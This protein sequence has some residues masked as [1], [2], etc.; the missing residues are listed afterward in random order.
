[1]A[2]ISR[3]KLIELYRDLPSDVAA[4][5]ENASTS[6]VMLD[7]GRKNSIPIDQLGRLSYEVGL[8]MVGASPAREFIGNIERGLG[9]PRAKAVEI[10]RD[11]NT[12]LFSPIRESLKR[13]HKLGTSEQLIDE[14][15]TSAQK[16][17]EPIKPAGVP[18]TAP[19]ALKI[20]EVAKHI[21]LDKP[22]PPAPP[23]TPEPAKPIIPTLLSTPTAQKIPEI[24]NPVRTGASKPADGSI[25]PT[26]GVSSFTD[27]KS[28]LSSNGVKPNLQAPAIAPSMPKVATPPVMQ[29][30]Y[31]LRNQT[32]QSQTPTYP[33]K[34]YTPVTKSETPPP[35][36]PAVDKEK[37]WGELKG[38][39]TRDKEQGIIG[40]GLE[41]RSKKQ[42]LE[43]DGRIEKKVDEEIAL[44]QKGSLARIQAREES[45]IAANVRGLASQKSLEQEVGAII[46]KSPIPVPLST[47]PTPRPAPSVPQAPAEIPRLANGQPAPVRPPESS[48]PPKLSPPSAPAG[49]PTPTSVHPPQ[50]IIPPKTPAPP[51][52]PPPI[53]D[54]KQVGDPYRETVG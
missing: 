18:K 26:F 28:W 19:V 34:F 25:T 31:E 1:M 9:V 43:D 49:A 41:V 53:P 38:Q 24:I 20:S 21:A 36:T 47:L 33:L 4:V 15:E 50:P 52:P 48:V 12:R 6:E 2:R 39:G 10:A 13:I 8:V 45:R 16:V 54:Y 23:K 35:T 40:D 27:D 42:G 7:V 44:N 46:G 17:P 22:T 29:R 32:S 5:Y 3:E 30:A 37:F 14:R 11:I 51:S